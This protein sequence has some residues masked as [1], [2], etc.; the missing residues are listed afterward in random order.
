MAKAAEPPAVQVVRET[1]VIVVDGAP[2][3]YAKG[4]VIEADDP[5]LKTLPDKFGNVV[6]AHPI[7]RRAIRTAATTEVRAD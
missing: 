7:K 5:I 3:V 4:E 2:V 1:F 6:Y